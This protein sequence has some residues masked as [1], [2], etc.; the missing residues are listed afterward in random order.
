VSRLAAFLDR[1]GTIV[2]DTGFLKD[3]DRVTLIDGA[4]AAIRRLNEA[5]RAVV[6]V[7]NQS[8]IARGLLSEADYARVADRIDRLLGALGARVD[9]TY[10]CPHYPEVS[11]PCECRKPGLKHYREAASRFGV[12][13]AGSAY[14]G[15]RTTD[16]LPAL[17]TGGRG[18]L[19]LTGEGELYRGESAGLGFEVATDLAAAVALLLE[20]GTAS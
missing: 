13:L 7:T 11:G 14:I 1:D 6:V 18:I 12:D 8:G 19:V 15:D 3:P 16:V 9:G 10:V 20:S 2:S 5:G 17:E 4:A